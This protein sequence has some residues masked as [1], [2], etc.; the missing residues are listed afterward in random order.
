M[1]HIPDFTQYGLLGGFLL[2]QALFL[3]FLIY[4]THKITSEMAE[5]RKSNIERD[6]EFKEYITEQRTELKEAHAICE[7]KIEAISKNFLDEIKILRAQFPEFHYMLKDIQKKI[8]NV[9]K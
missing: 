2:S 1:E 5:S 9:V 3:G 8:D 4:L 6:K 7:A